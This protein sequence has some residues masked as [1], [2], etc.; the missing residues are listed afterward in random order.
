MPV[1]LSFATVLFDPLATGLKIV[2]IF[3]LQKLHGGN[4]FPYTSI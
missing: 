4:G 2:K 3:N 1:Q